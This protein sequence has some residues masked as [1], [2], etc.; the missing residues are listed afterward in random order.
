MPSNMPSLW[1]M[2]GLFI[3]RALAAP[4]ACSS[5]GVDYVNGGSY[6]IDSSSSD[7]F[8]FTTMFQGC[9]QESV[10]PILVD[11]AG[12][13]YPCSAI[14]TTPDGEH[15]TSTCEITYSEMASGLY[16]IILSGDKI[17]VQRTIALTAGTPTTITITATPTVVIGVTSTPDATT[18]YKTIAQTQTVILTPGK[19][20]APCDGVTWTATITPKP[21]TLTSTSTITR[22]VTDLKITSFSYTTV[23]KTASCRYLTLLPT[24]PVP[25]PIPTICIG[26]ACLPPGGTPSAPDTAIL[27]TA[28]RDVEAIAAPITSTVTVTETTYTV[29]SS[30]VT[31]VPAETTTENVFETVTATIDT[32]DAIARTPPPTTVCDGTRPGTTVT[33]TKPFATVTQTDIAYSTKHTTATVWVGQTRYI[34]STNRASATSCRKRGGWYGVADETGSLTPG[35][36]PT[37]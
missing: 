7:D 32:N 1:V 17:G 28:K 13:Q 18:I 35:P 4:A 3:L 31:T 30:S 16:K 33:I 23:T 26:Y 19:V 29:T 20:T 11:P 37:P 21:S 8:T 34:T 9:E 24:F 14:D 27:K 5:Y 6:D 36:T 22:T 25:D 2:L 15:V 10:T 12:T